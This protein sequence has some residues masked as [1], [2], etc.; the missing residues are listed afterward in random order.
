MPAPKLLT[1][2]EVVVI[3]FSDKEIAGDPDKRRG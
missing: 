3:D 2:H 1:Y